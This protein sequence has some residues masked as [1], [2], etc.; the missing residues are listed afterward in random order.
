M[1]LSEGI[2]IEE[3]LEIHSIEYCVFGVVLIFLFQLFFTPHFYFGE[4]ACRHSKFKA[5]P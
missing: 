5:E 4:K 2:L 1:V 3:A